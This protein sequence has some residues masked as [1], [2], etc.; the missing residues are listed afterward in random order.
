MIPSIIVLGLLLVALSWFFMSGRDDASEPTANR[1]VNENDGIDRTELE[2]AERDVQDA[3]DEDS[4]R[5]WG[6]G[7]TPHP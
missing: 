6:P 1:R 7:K 2:Q 5:D 3:D 4:V